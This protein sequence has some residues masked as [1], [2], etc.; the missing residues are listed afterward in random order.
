[1]RT[2]AAMPAALRIFLLT[3]LGALAAF[4]PQACCAM[5][6][7]LITHGYAGNVDGWVTGMAD[8]VPAYQ[9]FPGTNSTCYTI[10][11]TSSGGNYYFTTT[12]VGGDAPASTGSGEIIVKLDWS[13]LA[14][15]LFPDSTYDVGWAT[16]LALQQTNL[17]AELGGHALTEFPLHLIGHS[18]GGSLMSEL[19]RD[20]GTNGLWVDHLTTLDP[21]PLNNDG[22]SDLPFTVDA[23]VRTYINVLFHDNYWQNLGGTLLVPNGEPV[24]GAYARQLYTLSGGYSSSHSDVH[25]WYHG[26]ID[27]ATPTTDT[28]ASLTSAERTNWWTAYENAGVVAG[29]DYS[30]IG[31]GDRLSADQPL[32][33]GFGT[34]RDGYNQW[35]DLGAGISSNRTALPS[36]SGNWP[37]LIRFNRIETKQVAQSQSTPVRFYYQWARPETNLATVSFYLDDDP[38]PLNGNDTL[39]KQVTVPATGA[40]N[41]SYQTVSLTLE[42]TNA[43]LGIHTLYAKIAGG[44][45]TRYLCAPEL[46]EVISSRE[47]PSLDIAAIGEMVF[48][49]GVNGAAGQAI[50]LELSSDI[51]TWLPLATNTLATDRWVYTNS[52]PAATSQ[53]FYRA[54]LAQ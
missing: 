48:A 13:T 27:W 37:N 50:V 15:G 30:L 46:V 20:L 1:M 28:E 53:Q 21:H 17:I 54:V 51:E 8:R 14:G 16:S 35:W 11:I 33:Q 10:E 34:I 40:S 44:S 52:P 7:T 5:G 41:V 38:N 47:P 18:R 22:F 26:T 42:A 3:S 49:I 43:T 45:R 31:G 24:F 9:R 32:G 25:L 23:P 29:F 39:L 4:E 12:R 36:I 6:V 2:K 19:S